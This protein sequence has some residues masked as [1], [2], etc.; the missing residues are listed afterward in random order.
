MITK[1]IS[2]K[3]LLKKSSAKYLRKVFAS[4]YSKVK[5]KNK[6]D[7]INRLSRKRF[8]KKEAARLTKNFRSHLSRNNKKKSHKRKIVKV[9]VKPKII[10]E[11]G[12]ESKNYYYY[13]TEWLPISFD[14]FW[15][16]YGEAV[17]DFVEKHTKSLF[18]GFRYE[19]SRTIGELS[20]R[21]DNLFEFSHHFLYEDF[22]GKNYFAT[23]EFDSE[24]FSNVA[25]WIM[26]VF[27][28]SLMR[29]VDRY[30][31]DAI[32]LTHF[33]IVERKE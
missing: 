9:K 11:L 30:R 16:T 19:S 22:F 20:Y 18:V 24:D 8:S 1:H 13:R 4:V 23:M 31:D 21:T 17:Q 26:H 29:K 2:F 5:Y 7:A 10:F 27:G 6:K 28:V 15:S 14:D 33:Y 12:Y 25:L 32:Y 3:T